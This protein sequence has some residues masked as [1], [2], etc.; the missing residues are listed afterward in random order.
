MTKDVVGGRLWP[1][2]PIVAEGSL[3]YFPFFFVVQF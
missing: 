1:F 3:E 2:S